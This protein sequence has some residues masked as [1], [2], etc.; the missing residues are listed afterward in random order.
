MTV[1]EPERLAA[2]SPAEQR[3]VIAALAENVAAGMESS[4]AR[5]GKDG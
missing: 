2:L 3:K 5:S 4:F 1:E